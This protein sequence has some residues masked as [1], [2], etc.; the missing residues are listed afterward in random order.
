ML[1]QRFLELADL[2]NSISKEIQFTA[3]NAKTAKCLRPRLAYGGNCAAE[4]ADFTLCSSVELKERK[5]MNVEAMAHCS[6][7]F[8]IHFEKHHIWV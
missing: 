1:I 2:H 6:Q 4:A 5:H 8:L 3:E 7:L